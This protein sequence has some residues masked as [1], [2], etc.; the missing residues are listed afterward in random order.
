MKEYIE[1]ASSEHQF[2][3]QILGE[4]T[5]FIHDS[6]YPSEEKEIAKAKQFIDSFHHLQEEAT[7]LSNHNTIAFTKKAETASER[8]KDFK[9]SM[10]KRQVKGTIGLHLS[11]TFLNHM[12]NEVEE[13]I[14]VMN[15][16][17]EGK[18]APIF[19]ELHHHLIWLIGAAGHAGVIHAALD[20]V[21][22]QRKK[23][24]Y[25]FVK[26]F[27]EYYVKAIELTG[28][29]RATTKTFPALKKFNRE[30]QMEV[31]SFHTFLQELNNMEHDTSLLNSLPF[32]MTD[33]MVREVTYYLSKLAESTNPHQNA[34]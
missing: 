24:S 32:N 13:Y 16:L 10:I 29:L 22:K 25:E 3:L 34:N 2:W 8:L 6:L 4:H 26:H 1:S 28:Y 14:L 23:R 31:E 17:K 30:V 7:N 19:H 27:E 18:A 21:E 5:Q 12:V 9:H 33:H 20:A 15:Y 11:P